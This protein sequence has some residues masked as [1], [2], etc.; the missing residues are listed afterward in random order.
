MGQANT[1]P[2]AC[3]RCTGRAAVV[4]PAPVGSCE[5]PR[6]DPARPRTDAR[7]APAAAA[8]AR[9]PP[10]PRVRLQSSSQ[11]LRP[12]L[13]RAAQRRWPPLPPPTPRDSYSVR[14][15][16]QS[17]R[18]WHPLWAAARASVWPP[19][20]HRAPGACCRAHSNDVSA[21]PPYPPVSVMTVSKPPHRR[22][23]YVAAGCNN[24]HDDG[25]IAGIAHV[26]GSIG[27]LPDGD[28]DRRS[29]ACS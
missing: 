27:S 13:S 28:E 1:G 2:G 6:P 7:Q 21:F 25:S 18:Y 19:A 15:R 20:A 9:P 10:P 26:G 29:C 8:M 12:R 24:G 5:P 14:T 16:P 22:A 17:R 3:A 23:Q 4:A 11:R